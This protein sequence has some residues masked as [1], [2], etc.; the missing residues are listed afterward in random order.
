[1]VKVQRRASYGFTRLRPEED[2]G[3][4]ITVLE[5]EYGVTAPMTIAMA[6]EIKGVNA[7][8][9]PGATLSGSFFHDANDNGLWD[10]D[11]GGMLSGKVR[12]LSEDGEIDLYQT[13]AEDGSYFF[14]GVMPGSIR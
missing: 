9:L 12:L 1:M 13:P 4:H 8:M 10:E 11:E 7:G 14:D 6:Q 3:S 5:G 2:G